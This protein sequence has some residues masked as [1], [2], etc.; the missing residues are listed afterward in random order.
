YRERAAQEGDRVGG[1][2][3]AAVVDPGCVIAGLFRTTRIAEGGHDDV[4]GGNAC[5]RTVVG[6]VGRQD[7]R[8]VD[9][10][11]GVDHDRGHR[12]V[13]DGDLDGRV[14]FALA[15]DRVA[16]VGVRAEDAEGAVAVVDDARRPALRIVDAGGAD[17]APVQ[18][19][20]AV[21]RQIEAA[22]VQD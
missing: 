7:L 1:D 4:A 15:V 8:I 3:A 17:E 22:R 12:P 21:G 13:P 11:R 20:V 16:G 2:V 5:L 10:Q 14:A 18:G 9:G 19:L 6:A